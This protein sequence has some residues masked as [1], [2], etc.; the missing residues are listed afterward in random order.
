M[1]SS[2][3]TTYR[4]T[5]ISERD[6]T[7][8]PAAHY[9]GKPLLLKKAE[10]RYNLHTRDYARL[11]AFRRELRQFLRFSEEAAERAGLTAQH[12]QAMLILRACPEGEAVS[13]IDLARELL[14]R[15]NSAV[16]L[17]DRLVTERL[18]LREAS[19]AD[20]RRVE[21]RLS[22]R[23]RQVLARLA[24]IHRD[25]LERIGPALER[26]IAAIRERG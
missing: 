26:L 2:I 6:I 22:A 10:R 13:I 25:E 3:G 1:S 19:E 8:F 9:W 5:I 12:Y 20:R 14:I 24:Q 18:V 15:H 21:L 17:V 7:W 23:G 4:D 11:A 16:G